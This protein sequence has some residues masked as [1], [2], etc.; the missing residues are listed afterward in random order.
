MWECADYICRTAES[1]SVAMISLS[2]Q[3]ETK[4]AK[5]NVEELDTFVRTDARLSMVT[6]SCSNGDVWS[7]C[8]NF[9]ESLSNVAVCPET[10]VI[11]AFQLLTAAQEY[12]TSSRAPSVFQWIYRQMEKCWSDC[13]RS[14]KAVCNEQSAGGA[15]TEPKSG[16]E[17]K[18]LCH[19]GKVVFLVQLVIKNRLKQAPKLDE[20]FVLISLH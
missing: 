8:F 5:T 12:R 4:E 10:T 18:W 11:S 7:V 9:V 13:L 2:A 14:M 6:A 3:T 1:V 15:N 20:G 17:C 16:H 19:Q